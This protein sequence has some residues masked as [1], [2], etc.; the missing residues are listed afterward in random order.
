VVSPPA[1]T[2]TQREST[3]GSVFAFKVHRGN[4]DGRDRP[5]GDL[6]G[7]DDDPSEAARRRGLLH[8]ALGGHPLGGN[9]DARD[10][11]AG[12]GLAGELLVG[13]HHRHTQRAARG[14]RNREKVKQH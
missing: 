11:E 13:H 2:Q 1:S 7:G 10:R 5:R 9:V 14:R 6:S 12:N 4:R 3:S 8:G